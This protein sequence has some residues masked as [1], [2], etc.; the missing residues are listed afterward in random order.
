VHET[1]EETVEEARTLRTCRRHHERLVARHAAQ[2]TLDE[3]LDR[4]L[5]T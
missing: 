5:V 4:D 2:G 1:G 3:V